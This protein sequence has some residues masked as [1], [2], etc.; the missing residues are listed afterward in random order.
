MIHR[1]R[2]IIVNVTCGESGHI[3]ELQLH[4]DGIYKHKPAAHVS[5]GISRGLNLELDGATVTLA[6]D[7]SS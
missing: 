3:G 4:L 2:D 7:S 5:Y 6:S 1:Y